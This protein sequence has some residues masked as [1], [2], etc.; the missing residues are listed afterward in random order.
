MPPTVRAWAQRVSCVFSRRGD[1]YNQEKWSGWKLGNL[2]PLVEPILWFQK[3]YKIGGTI[4]DN[5]LN[6]E[7]G[8]YNED[9]LKT[10]EENF[11]RNEGIQICSNLIR[12]G[13]EDYDSGLHPT[14]KPLNLIK[15]LIGLVT[16]ENQVILDPF[17]GSGTTL[18]AAKEMN[19][20]YIGFEQNA[21][22]VTT[23]LKRLES[24]GGGD[25]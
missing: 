14:Q 22:F 6:H 9:F 25:N 8:A 24:I 5:L 18:V 17:C 19:R 21:D 12:I 10:F 23:S 16:K 11:S 13:K 1:S 15:L 7:V 3:P 20:K 2:R 4:S